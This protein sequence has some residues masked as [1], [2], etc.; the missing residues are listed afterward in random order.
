MKPA[1]PD[2]PKARALAL[3]KLLWPWLCEHDISN[4]D[5]IL[6]YTTMVCGILAETKDAEMAKWVKERVDAIAGSIAVAN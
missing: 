2:D 1:L 6:L 3:M 5:A 4:D